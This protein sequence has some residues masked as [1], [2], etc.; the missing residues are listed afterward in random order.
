M[1]FELS[2]PKG[3]PPLAVPPSRHYFYFDGSFARRVENRFIGSVL[4]GDLFFA[5]RCRNA[6]LCTNAAEMHNTLASL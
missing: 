6:P 3:V 2:R 1:I 5:L 4:K